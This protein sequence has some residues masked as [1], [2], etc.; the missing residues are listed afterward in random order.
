MPTRRWPVRP[1]VILGGGFGGVSRAQRLEQLFARDPHLE[2]ALVSQSTYLLFT[3]MLA[4]VA[5]SGLE[6]QHISAPVRAACPHTRFVRAEVEGVD[7]A[8]QVVHVR[9]SPSGPVETL[10]YDHLLLA[11]GAAPNFYGLPGLEGRAFTLKTPDDATR[12]R[13]H[14][15][16]LLD[17]ADVRSEERRVGKE[18]RSR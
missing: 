5:S 18:G 6:A 12:L 7:T 9:A 11:L 3:P 13:D 16:A 8:A 15:I 14:V 1:I 10:P 17:R 2:T 4:E